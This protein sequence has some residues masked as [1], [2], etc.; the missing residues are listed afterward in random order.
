MTRPDTSLT[1]PGPWRRYARS[2]P[3][4]PDH[5][6]EQRLEPLLLA[7]GRMVFAAGSL[8]KLLLADIAQRTAGQG[9]VTAELGQLV[10]HLERRPAGELVGRL[11]KLGISRELATCLEGVL[12]RRNRVVHHLLD[13]P[14]TVLAIT[15]GTGLKQVVD[16]VDNVTVE[17][18]RIMEA[19]WPD[20]SAGMEAIVQST[21]GGPLAD[22]AAPVRTLDPDTLEDDHLRAV[23]D[24]AQSVDPGDLCRAMDGPPEHQ[25]ST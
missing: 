18:Q 16:D 23:V 14:P 1:S 3:H 22:V 17:C 5:E 4:G 6:F 12:Q 10:V 2:M 19:L 13:D 24:Y 20:A 15:T 25:R 8:E 21:L 7:I 11:R 9:G